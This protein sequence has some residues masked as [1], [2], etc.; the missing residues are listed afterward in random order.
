MTQ[1]KC[2]NQYPN[3]NDPRII[4]I[5]ENITKCDTHLTSLTFFFFIEKQVQAD[6]EKS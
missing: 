2:V 6:L 1:E 4:K 5:Q 3:L